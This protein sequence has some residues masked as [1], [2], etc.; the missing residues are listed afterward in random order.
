MS[1]SQFQIQTIEYH[2][3]TEL[4]HESPLTL[5]EKHLAELI[6]LCQD[7]GIS[8]EGDKPTLIKAL[9][10]WKLNTRPVPAPS[11][12]KLFSIDGSSGLKQDKICS[13]S[14]VFLDNDASEIKYEDL[15]IGRKIGSG[16]F[17]DCYE[18]KYKEQSVAIG[19]L[20][21]VNFSESDLKETK[22]EINVLKQLRHENIIQFIGISTNTKQL[23]I[24]TEFCENGDLFDYMRKVPRPPFT[25]QI[26]FMHDIA[27]G[28]TYL[29]T[30]RP[31]I[32]HRDLKSMNI[33]ISSNLRA[34]INDF[35][36]ARIRP[37]ANA[38]MHT[39]CG[40]P[41]WQAPEF[42]TPNPSYTEKVDVYAAA[43][44]FWEILTWG[45]AGYPYHNYN[46]HQ[47]YEAVRDRNVRPSL[48]ELKNYPTT[49]LLLIQD[50]WQKLPSARPS[51]AQV[52][53]SLVQYL[54]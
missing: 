43:L 9:L 13:L 10:D 14:S 27:L 54:N 40:T 49:L 39:Q 32:I 3:D 50:M 7:R 34:K 26:M 23:F 15:E 35:G 41:N 6:T 51:M 37:K 22:H 29:H 18:G 47:L 4:E 48:I 24:I 46:E 42:W 19:E 11:T 8:I 16:G 12:P 25:Q 36:L 20:R 17:K 5:S 38:S 1:P 52:V 30:R 45:E 28:I 21:V 2:I 31:S 53:E 33:L 44:I